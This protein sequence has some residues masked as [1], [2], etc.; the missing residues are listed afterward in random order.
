[1]AARTTRFEARDAG[2]TVVGRRRIRRGA[3][4]LR[5]AF[6]VCIGLAL[7]AAG[8][9][10][11]QGGYSP[12]LMIAW[13]S[14]VHASRRGPID[15]T[16]PDPDRELASHGTHQEVLG[17]P[18]GNSAGVFSLGDGGSITLF[19][20]TGIADGPGDDFAVYEN[21]FFSVE[22]L[23]AEF[24]F[25]D[26][27]TN[28][29]DFAR[30][31]AASLHAQPVASFEAVDPNDYD[32]FAGDQPLGLGTG[33]DLSALAG[34]PLVT[35][36]VVDLEDVRYVRLVDV[37]GNGTTFDA[38]GQPIYD[39]HPTAFPSGGFD[40]D[41]VGVLH[42][43]EPGAHAMLASGVACLAG[44]ARRRRGACRGAAPPPARP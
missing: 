17:P 26:V 11:G 36:G 41:A 22:G 14:A 20:A 2:E 5:G 13:A 4:C 10:S 32:R 8:P 33:F 12:G 19:F 9:A 38:N 16:D 6:P 34:D 31:Q 37:V 24:A 1:M 21:G 30:F 27:S 40:A 15:I 43:P 35:A 39:P 28:G 44:L 23:F 42:V 3:S 7:G 29:V 25:V 18:D